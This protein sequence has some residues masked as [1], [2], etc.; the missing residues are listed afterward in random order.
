MTNDDKLAVHG[1]TNISGSSW[2]ILIF[3]ARRGGR[4]GLPLCHQRVH[5]VRHRQAAANKL[6]LPFLLSVINTVL[7]LF[8]T[9]TS[10]SR[11][12]NIVLLEDVENRRMYS[13]CTLYSIPVPISGLA[14]LY[15]SQ[16]FKIHYFYLKFCITFLR[17]KRI[18]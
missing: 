1:I 13:N 18:H 12:L 2:P 11:S 16:I 6:S 4:E 9:S 14:K 15:L 10:I 7:S 3:Q 8:T 17:A 5:A